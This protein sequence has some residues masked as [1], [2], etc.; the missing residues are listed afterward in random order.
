MI[1]S[2]WQRALHLTREPIQTED[3]IKI[4]RFKVVSERC[5]EVT[6]QGGGVHTIS[7]VQFDR[8]DNKNLI[9]AD[10]TPGQLTHEAGVKKGQSYIAGIINEIIKRGL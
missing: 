4:L 8:V 10:V 9:L 3:R 5:I 7:R 1:A 2:F 6:T